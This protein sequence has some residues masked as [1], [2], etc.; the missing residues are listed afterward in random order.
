MPL[1]DNYSSLSGGFNRRAGMK[2]AGGWRERPRSQFNLAVASSSPDVR[3][4]IVI[5]ISKKAPKRLNLTID[6]HLRSRRRSPSAIIPRANKSGRRRPDEIWNRKRRF[7]PRDF[8]DL[9]A[10]LRDK[11]YNR[12]E[13]A[14]RNA[15]ARIS[16]ESP[17]DWQ[18]KQF[19]LIATSP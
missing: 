19:T 8:Y 7:P 1:R 18:V 11:F 9:P 14:G 15:R 16:P 10:D 5:Y 6:R 12:G 13:T 2:V 3:R 4:A 17:Q